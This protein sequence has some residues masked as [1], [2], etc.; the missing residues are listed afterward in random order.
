MSNDCLV[1]LT[2]VTVRV[3]D[4]H[5]LHN[6]TWSIARGQ[7]WVVVGP[8]GSGK[9]SLVRALAGELP[10]SAGNRT[11]MPGVRIGAVSF[12]AQQ[13]M[14]AAEM[15]ADHGRFYAGRPD[16]QTTVAGLLERIDPAT[17]DRLL[18]RFTF[19]Q[20]LNRSLRNLSAGEMRKALIIRALGAVPDLLVLDEPF[21]GLDELTRGRL[22]QVVSEVAAGGV[23][24]VVVTH[25]A[26]EV[27]PVCTHGLV[28]E[29][30]RVVFQGPLNEAAVAITRVLDPPSPEPSSPEQSLPEL[31]SPEQPS[32]EPSSPEQP[33]ANRT[34]IGAAQG[35]VHAGVAPLVEFRALN[36][37]YGEREVF[38]NLSW[39]VHSGEHWAVLGANGS[40]KTTLVNL[41]SG[42][43]VQ[44]YANDIRLFGCRKGQGESVW[45]IKARIGVVTPHLQLTYRAEVTVLEAVASGFFDSVGLYRR[46]SAEQLER[47]RHLLA[48]FGVAALADRPIR[49]ISY[50]QRRLVLIARALVKR[51]ELLLLDEPCQGLDTANRRVVIAAIDA[52]CRTTDSTV[53]FI[54]HHQDEIPPAI[55]RILHLPTPRVPI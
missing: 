3:R 46:P 55:E 30:G 50:G 51:P 54:T 20:F 4:H 21:D 9:S 1:S 45:D 38:R 36:V 39:T 27:P 13:S 22:M 35:T 16:A 41:I 28:V 8:N 7:H 37:R 19:T 48:G 6:T 40:G 11:V 2:A 47:A 10:T 49:S 5:L 52:V 15:D 12:E 53:V 29:G 23:G 32:P 44:G 34:P 24:V 14:L 25:R 17:R 31:P 18:T 33:S 42:E 43:N 26:E